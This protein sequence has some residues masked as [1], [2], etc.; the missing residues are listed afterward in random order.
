M[1]RD[2][3]KIVHEEARAWLSQAQA[4]WG[5]IQSQGLMSEE[6]FWGDDN[7][8]LSK[9]SRLYEE[10]FQLAKLTDESDLLLHAEGPGAMHENPSLGTVNW[11]SVRMEKRLRALVQA[12][13]PLAHQEARA[14]ARAMDLRF[15]GIAPG[16][17]YMGFSIGQLRSSLFGMEEADADALQAIRAALQSIPIVPQFVGEN[18]VSDGLFEALP[19]PALRDAAMVAAYEISPTGH[20][21]IH[22]LEI[23]APRTGTSVGVLGQ[24]ERVV[25]KEATTNPMMKARREGAF[26]GEVREV[27]L[28]SRRF[29]LRGV[30][31]VGTLRCVSKFDE[32]L[33]KS[34]LGKTVTVEGQYDSDA[35]GRPRL[36][37]VWHYRIHQEARQNQIED[38]GL[39]GLVEE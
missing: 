1:V 20:K 14:A 7:P 4:A 2:T 37:T 22:T 17:L 39:F 29:Q 12:I 34:V 21:G 16:S 31:G 5:I 26:T 32:Q 28:D 8:Y 10:D 18:E 35:S 15:N 27:D 38:D 30:D 13:S 36:M 25:L 6:E 3:R 24:R 11:L 9:V 33:A 23:S 19:D